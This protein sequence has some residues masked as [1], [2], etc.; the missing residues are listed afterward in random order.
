M[1]RRYC[2]EAAISGTGSSL[3]R[4]DKVGV[5]CDGSDCQMEATMRSA[6][7]AIPMGL[8]GGLHAV[9]AQRQH[10]GK[11]LRPP[12][13]RRTGIAMTVKN[14]LCLWLSMRSIHLNDRQIR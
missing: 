11:A 6:A 2:F 10:R 14:R 5:Q 4:I 13:L 3:E 8:L 7:I 9:A 12:R 1:D